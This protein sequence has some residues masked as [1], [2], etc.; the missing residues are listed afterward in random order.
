LL[1]INNRF[2]FA[3]PKGLNE[4]KLPAYSGRVLITSSNGEQLSVPYQGVAFD[5]R[6]QFSKRMFAGEYP[7]MR[8]TPAYSNKTT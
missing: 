4:T 5:M 2:T 1:N 3:A 6:E 7:Y 8:S